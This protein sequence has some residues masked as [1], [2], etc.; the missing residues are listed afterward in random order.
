MS[1]KVTLEKEVL[2]FSPP[3][4]EST[5]K[6]GVYA[7]PRMWREIDG[8]LVIRFNGEIDCGDTDNMYEIS[9]L[10]FVSED[11]G[12][13]WSFVENGDEKFDIG[14]LNGIENPY[15]HTGEN[16]IAF[17]EKKDLKSIKDVPYK[18]EFMYP[19]KEALVRSYR[20]GDIPDKCKGLEILEY[21]D[22]TSLPKVSAVVI[23]F[24]EREILINAKGH[25]GDYNYV[26]VE[27]RVKQNIFKN[28][29]INSVR[30]LSDGSLGAVACGQNPLVDDHY[31]GVAYFMVSE[32]K[33]HTWKKRGTIAQTM[34]LPY[35]YTGDGHEVSL[36]VT[37]DGVL[38]CAMRMDVSI[39]EEPYGAVVAYSEDNG[40]TWSK[41]QFVSDASVTPHIISLDNGI[42]VLVYGRP[43]VH[44][45]YSLDNGRTWSKSHSI[46]GKTLAEYRKECDDDY[47]IKYGDTCSYSNTFVE[48]LS[49]DE[50]LVLYNNLKYDEGDGV[51]HKAA[52]VRKI[53]IEKV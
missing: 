2:V 49:G 8:R 45:K 26:D 50:F 46:I 4:N 48:K 10:F 1:V 17:R 38:V 42:V 9:N 6:W 28:N 32:D 16:I 30:L 37:K 20:Y 12:K 39:M 41:P 52:F 47:K 29:Y 35:G 36:S 53:K 3:V 31:S 15:I 40:Y 11:D 23:D 24:P 21:K 34:E 43:G 33:G 19:T 51:H 14:I 5:K 7:I 22:A 25:R 27:E 44:F 18:K 13:S